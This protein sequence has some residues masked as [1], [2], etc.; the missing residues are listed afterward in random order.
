M[1]T[2]KRGGGWV[3]GQFIIM[4]VI[5][6]L[7]ATDPYRTPAQFWQIAVA[8]ALMIDALV[9]GYFAFAHLGRNLTPFPKPKDDGELVT[10]GIYKYVRHPIYVAVIVASTGYA[11]YQSSW[12]SGICVVA[13]AIWFE[14]KSRQEEVFLRQ[15][16]REYTD[17]AQRVKKF[18]PFVY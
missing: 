3:V 8:V 15:R 2:S 9:I 13:L 4:A 18:I 11:I 14:L 5:L 10:T 17:Y 1:S 6:I 16:F 12:L 7:G